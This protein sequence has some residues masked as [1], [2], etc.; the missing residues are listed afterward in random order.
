MD[1]FEFLMV[2]LSI[3]VGLGISELLTNVARQIRARQTCRPFWVHS[4][5][6]VLLFLAFLQIWW[7]SWGLRSVEI[8]TFPALLL[9][10]AGPAG[11][12]VISHL[13]YPDEIE[14]ADLESYYFKNAR[15]LWSIAALTVVAASG[16]RPLAFGHEL[17]QM[18]NLSSFLML[19]LFAGLAVSKHRI[20]HLAALPAV[21][22]MLIL[23]IMVFKPV[24]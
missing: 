12:F 1:R 6:V 21:L 7:E 8:W 23:D 24:L 10:L 18:D 14:G 17:F 22:A 3:I 16:F 13:I 4:G 20:L 15:V 5:V 2:L 9:M 19:G 11:L